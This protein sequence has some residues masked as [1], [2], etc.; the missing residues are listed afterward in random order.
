MPPRPD[1]LEEPDFS[2]DAE[3]SVLRF[4]SKKK[5]NKIAG[6]RSYEAVGRAFANLRPYQRDESWPIMGFLIGSHDIAHNGNEHLECIAD[7]CIFQGN[8]T[9]GLVCL[10]V[11][12]TS[13]HITPKVPDTNEK[14][15]GSS[16]TLPR[17]V[18]TR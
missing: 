4:W 12:S 16:R 18:S 5:G 13:V 17:N 11:A 1:P 7:R 10:A 2:T 14:L 8:S 15:S 9:V 3:V 6:T